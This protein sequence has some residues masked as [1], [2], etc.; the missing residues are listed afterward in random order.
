MNMHE[1]TNKEETAEVNGV[2]QES[3]LRRFLYSALRVIVTAII[4]SV[5]MFN[6]KTPYMFQ[7]PGSCDDTSRFIT[8]ED[9]NKINTHGRFFITTVIYEPANLMLYLIG[10]FDPET[11]LTHR[12][13]GETRK[14]DKKR[15]QIMKDQMEESKVK[16]KI[17]AFRALGYK[18]KIK[19]SPVQVL[20]VAPWSKAKGMLKEGDYIIELDDKKILNEL[21]LTNEIKKQADTGKVNLTVMRTGK[22]GSDS[23]EKLKF[24]IPLT[25]KRGSWKIGINILSKIEDYKLPK[26]VDIDSENIIGSSAGLMFT[27]EIMKQVS[28]IDLTGGFRIAGTGS[29]DENGKVYA[30]EGVRFKILA[31]ERKKCKYFFCPKDNYGEAK[32]AAKTIKVISVENL[33]DALKKLKEFNPAANIEEYIIKTRESQTKKN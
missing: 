18:V 17:A 9:D 10:K 15:D 16:A 3:T 27:L 19:K 20:A 25:K 33:D 21:E 4:L 31:A 23:E 24:T 7:A 6:V 30:I 1:I 8:V 2:Q 22:N 26:K 29:I 12:S 32:A 14:T 11:G 5:I 13:E 28:R